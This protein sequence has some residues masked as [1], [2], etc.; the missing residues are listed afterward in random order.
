GGHRY[1]QPRGTALTL[2]EDL[3]VIAGLSPHRPPQRQFLPAQQLERAGAMKAVDLRPTLRRN[4]L[5]RIAQNAAA[6]GVEVQDVP[7]E[8]HDDRPVRHAVQDRS[9]Q[10]RL[11]LYRLLRPCRVGLQVPGAGL[12]LLDP[13]GLLLEQPA[14]LGQPAAA[15]VHHAAQRL[16]RVAPQLLLALA[17]HEWRS[18]L[19]DAA[20]PHDDRIVNPTPGLSP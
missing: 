11:L 5:R 12:G 16:Q 7:P 13:L 15:L 2:D 18:L 20:G 17:L 3:Y 14:H 4:G 10:A 8:I 6:S 1:R 19:Q 9:Q